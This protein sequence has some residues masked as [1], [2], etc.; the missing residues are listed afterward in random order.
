[1]VKDTKTIAIINKIDLETNVDVKY[2]KENFKHIVEISAKQKNGVKQLETAIN[3]ILSLSKLDSN[4][5]IIANER[6]RD[7][8]FRAR[9]E[10]ENA[11]DAIALGFS[12]DA[13]TVSIE[14][15]LD[16]LLELSGKKASQSIVDEVFSHFCVGK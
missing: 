7:C 6:Q 8:A 16:A 11:I 9:E 1:M 14:M 10:I 4:S 13:V 15:A 2:I 3:D 5:A 12:L